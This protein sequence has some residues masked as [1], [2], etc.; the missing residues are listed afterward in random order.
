MDHASLDDR[1]RRVVY[2]TTLRTGVPPSIDALSVSA[3]V[4]AVELRQSLERLAL[5]RVFVLQPF[6][7]ELLMVPPFSAAPTPFQVT[8]NGTSGYANCVWDAIGIPIMARTSA[9]VST[10]CGCCGERMTFEVRSDVPL[11]GDGVV[12]FAVPAARWWENIVF[13]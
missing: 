4:S 5:A 12:H 3:L 8:Y 10:A 11:A 2:D 1:V 7:G 13:T 9:V 6:S